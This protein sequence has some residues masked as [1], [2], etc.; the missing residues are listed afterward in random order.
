M[1]ADLSANC[2]LIQSS[3]CRNTESGF[4]LIWM[5]SECFWIKHYVNLNLPINPSHIMV[6][7]RM[8][9][10]ARLRENCSPSPYSNASAWLMERTW[11]VIEPSILIMSESQVRCVF[12]PKPEFQKVLQTL[13][14]FYFNQPVGRFLSIFVIRSKSIVVSVVM[15]CHEVLCQLSTVTSLKESRLAIT[16]GPPTGHD[17]QPAWRLLCLGMTGLKLFNR[18]ALAASKGMQEGSQKKSANTPKEEM[19]QSSQKNSHQQHPSGITRSHLFTSV[20]HFLKLKL[21]LQTI[22]S[23]HM[24]APVCACKQGTAGTHHA[25]EMRYKGGP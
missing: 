1:A 2:C 24:V 17:A 16:P 18:P 9:R 12:G 3:I 6:P 25:V 11:T 13:G 10:R 4:A 15:K 8:W 7:S 5:R 19:Q 23:H 21:E 14:W 22:A 20:L